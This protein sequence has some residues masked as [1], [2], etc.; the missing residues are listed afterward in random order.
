MVTEKFMQKILAEFAENLDKTILHSP[1]PNLLKG[2]VTNCN[3]VL[4]W[5]YYFVYLSM[6]LFYGSFRTCAIHVLDKGTTLRDRPGR[7][8]NYQ[9][10]KN[11]LIGL[12]NEKKN[13]QNNEV[14]RLGNEVN[15]FPLTVAK[16]HTKLI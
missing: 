8:K 10:R 11:E 3:K 4:N 5:T 2:K 6:Q 16:K 1:L 7:K 9:P 15:A 13:N 14:Q 12:F